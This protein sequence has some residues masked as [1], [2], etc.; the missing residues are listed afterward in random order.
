[1]SFVRCIRCLMPTTRPSTHFVDGVCSACLNYEKRKAIDWE[2]R[3]QE[4]LRIVE[5]LPKNDSGYQVIVAS[6]G[7]KDSTA[8]VLKMLELGVKPLVVTASTCHLT[9]TGRLNIDNLKRFATTIE[10]SPNKVVRAAL[11][12][13]GLY[14]VGDISLPEHF[15]I[16]STPFRAA[17]EFGIPTIIYGESPQFEYGSPPGEEEAKTMTRRWTMEHGGFLGMR[18]ADCAGADLIKLGDMSDYML[19]PSEK[20]ENVT[21]YFLGQ[22]YPWDSHANAEL[23]MRAGLHVRLPHAGNRWLFENLDNAQ[24]GIHDYFGFLKYGYGRYCAQASVD[25]RHGRLTREEGYD[26]VKKYDHRFPATYMGIQHSEI[27]GRIDVR[28]EEFARLLR[29][30]TNSELFADEIWS[31]SG[32]PLSVPEER[33]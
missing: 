5:R 6:S 28:E 17:V 3:E 30:F 18:P 29:K 7:G 23:A 9:D 15:A 8:Q 32:M 12:R 21:A 13:V 27:I 31:T 25:I 2:A 14:V 4:F 22:Y 20:M 16:F 24:T 11:N 33:P 1:M 19:P 10:Y 26:L